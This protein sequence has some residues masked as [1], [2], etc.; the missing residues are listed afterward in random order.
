MNISLD[1]IKGYSDKRGRIAEIFTLSDLVRHNSKFGHL[2]LVTFDEEK[3]LRGNHYHAKKHEYY[4]VIEGKIKVVLLDV[5]TKERKVLILKPQKDKYQKLRIGPNIAHAC[6][7]LTP[8]AI[9]IGY[10][11][12]PYHKNKDTISYKIIKRKT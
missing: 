10:F 11:S 9:M 3:A 2:F 12:H 6:Y 4:I 5:K 8:K 1:L 7:N